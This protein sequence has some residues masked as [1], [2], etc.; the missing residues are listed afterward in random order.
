VISRLLDSI[1][2]SDL[3]RSFSKR[4]I[5]YVKPEGSLPYDIT[6]VP[7]YS[8]MPMFQYG[9]AK[10]HPELAQL[11]LFIVMEK[12]RTLSLSFETYS[13]SILDI[14]TLK[15]KVADLSIDG[16]ESILD[17]GFFSLD[18]LGILSAHDYIIAA[19]CSRKEVKIAFS[20]AIKTLD[21]GIT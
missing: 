8:S 15:R 21:S 4:F 6:S 16:A 19:V 9:H 17:R 2:E 3:Y 14:V 1:G 13:R 12:K 18:N 11:N 20:F 5:T 7:S 10:D